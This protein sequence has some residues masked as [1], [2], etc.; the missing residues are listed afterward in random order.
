MADSANE[1]PQTVSERIHQSQFFLT[2][3]RNFY[4]NFED[5][6]LLVQAGNHNCSHHFIFYRNYRFVV[7]LL[8]LL[9]KLTLSHSLDPHLCRPRHFQDLIKVSVCHFGFSS[10]D[11][12]RNAFNP[13]CIFNGY[14]VDLLEDLKVVYRG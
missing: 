14:A 5:A 6:M 9:L 1:I 13:G 2:C 10:F 8:P 3:C 7:V 4:H 12:S 11:F